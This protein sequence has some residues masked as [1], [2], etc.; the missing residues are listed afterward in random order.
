MAAKKRAAATITERGKNRALLA[1][2]LLLER[3]TGSVVDVAHRLVGLQAQ[4]PAPPYVGMWTRL[5]G[6]AR[7]DLARALEEGRIVRATSMRGTI[8]E[9]AADDFRRLRPALQPMLAEG[10]K[11]LNE[12]LAGIDVEAVVALARET[13][14]EGPK[15]FEAVRAVLGARWPTLDVR[16]MG[17]VARL[18]LPLV[19]VPGEGT[20]GFPTDPSFA[21]AERWLKQPMAKAMPLTELVRRYLAAFGPAEPRDFKTWSGLDARDAFAEL[22]PTLVTFED[23]KKRTLFDLPDAPRP[24]DDVPA[25]ARFLPEYDNVVMAHV[26]RRRIVPDE[27]RK[28]VY[29]PGL[30]VAPTFLIDGVVR[31]TW[32]HETKKK[33]ATLTLTA[34]APMT[35][36]EKRALEAEG[37]ALG[38]FLGEGAT[39]FAVKHA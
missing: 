17:Y 4:W 28:A 13:F 21:L 20:W 1:R 6:F 11:M 9:L 29:L 31:G 14:A 5:A 10:F 39:S 8:H 7:A 25:P 22:A 30:R 16:A 12:R 33:V 2:Q 36:K 34:L 15:P 27:F 37:E 35:A 19:Q 18:R 32:K 3:A 24:D 23:E 26:D 38:R